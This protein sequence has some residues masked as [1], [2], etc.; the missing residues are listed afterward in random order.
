MRF[1]QGTGRHVKDGV[2][3]AVGQLDTAL[4]VALPGPNEEVRIALEVLVE[5]LRAGLGKAELAEALAA[6]LRERLREKMARRSHR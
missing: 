6:R 4:I 3:I 1:Q 5:G 2:R